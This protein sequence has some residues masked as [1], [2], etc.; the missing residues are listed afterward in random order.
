MAKILTTGGV[1]FIGTALAQNLVAQGHEV[2][3]LDKYDVQLD[4]CRYF[5]GSVLDQWA[6][7]SHG[8]LRLCSTSCRRAG[9]AHVHKSLARMPRRQ[10]SRNTQH[11]R[12][13]GKV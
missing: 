9:R 13:C 12:V 7:L 6:I 1:G 11:A 8:G 10:H 3:V 4:N 2:H 5:R